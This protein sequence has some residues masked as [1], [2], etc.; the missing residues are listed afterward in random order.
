MTMQRILVCLV[1]VAAI[2]LPGCGET[3]KPGNQAVYDRIEATSDCA[4][5]QREFDVAMTNHDRATN[6][7]QQKT[8][9]AY[10]EAAQD[11]IEKL[12][13]P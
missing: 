2:I 10:A 13:C 12:T 8:S 11:R 6:D 5:L 7:E 9:L 4:K 1:A 3:E